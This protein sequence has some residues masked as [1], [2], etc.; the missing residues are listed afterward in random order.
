MVNRESNCI[1]L[2]GG[3][4]KQNTKF[5]IRILL[6]EKGKLT[7]SR[8]GPEPLLTTASQIDA[9]KATLSK[10]DLM[11]SLVHGAAGSLR[12]KNV[13]NLSK[14]MA[15]SHVW[16][17]QP[18]VHDMS[19]NVFPLCHVNNHK[20]SYELL[21][22]PGSAFS[23]S[24]KLAKSTAELIRYD[25]RSASY[26]KWAR[27]GSPRT[28]KVSSWPGSSGIVKTMYN[29]GRSATLD[30]ASSSQNRPVIN[31]RCSCET[32]SYW[33][34]AL[35]IA[36]W[37]RAMAWVAG[38]CWDTLQCTS[39]RL[40]CPSQMVCSKV[41]TPCQPMPPKIGGWISPPQIAIWVVNF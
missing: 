14:K 39:W 24:A 16:W 7:V 26:H 35:T 40:W 34:R 5:S 31:S 25:I 19:K 20:Y 15:T 3:W 10:K 38:E 18:T 8:S 29:S 32:W 33:R 22:V 12:A 36:L 6:Q 2:Q 13:V 27:I 30:L 28:L 21:S 17:R 9:R 11:R 37:P 4:S 23:H 41:T 1:A